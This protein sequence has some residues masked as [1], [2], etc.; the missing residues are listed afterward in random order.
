M[1]IL[2]KKKKRQNL[3]AFKFLSSK[4]NIK[5]E[6]MHDILYCNWRT[7]A[8]MSFIKD[9]NHPCLTVMLPIKKIIFLI[10]EWWV[11]LCLTVMFLINEGKSPT[12]CL[13]VLVM[14]SEFS[15][16]SKQQSKLDTI[17]NYFLIPSFSS[18]FTSHNINYLWT[19]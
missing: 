4:W 2:Y 14:S 15:F 12:T 3:Y 7:L 13:F 8:D 9:E 5:F 18:K 1:F 10:K 16:W 19:Y 11:K 17:L 6:I